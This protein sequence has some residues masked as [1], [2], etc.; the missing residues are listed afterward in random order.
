M[1][2]T[3]KLALFLLAAVLVTPLSA[4]AAN[5]ARVTS[6]VFPYSAQKS[7]TVT[8]TVTVVNTGTTTWTE[9]SA[10]RLGVTLNGTD[11]QRLFIVGGGSV[12]PGKGITFGYS[13]T[14]PATN[15]VYTY[16]FRMVRDGVEW[17]GNTVTQFL[18]AGDVDL[19]TYWPNATQ[20]ATHY[21]KKDTGCTVVG[22][23]LG[24]VMEVVGT[25]SVSGSMFITNR[26][27][28]VP[29]AVNPLGWSSAE[30]AFYYARGLLL[31]LGEWGYHGSTSPYHT[32]G[33]N[34][35]PLIAG[36]RW[37]YAGMNSTSA[38]HG[39]ITTLGVNDPTYQAPPSGVTVSPTTSSLYGVVTQ[40]GETSTTCSRQNKIK[41]RIGWNDGLYYEEL[42]YSD[43]VP[44]CG[45]GTMKKGLSRWLADSNKNA[46]GTAY[47]STTCA[48]DGGTW[49]GGSPSLCRIADFQYCWQPYSTP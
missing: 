6:V 21:L 19:Q 34:S 22:N 4:F 10:Y 28:T 14:T 23:D 40:T 9:A 41:S 46:A 33:Y 35:P 27:S 37:G 49:L 2:H 5:D 24:W 44:I 26:T 8:G 25:P 3:L 43:N 48:A 20:S 16:A 45:T 30:Q 47:T 7:T 36:W 29:A 38:I 17:F 11:D 12:A 39:A 18:L 13:F 1:K 32:A 31:V 42:W 15:G